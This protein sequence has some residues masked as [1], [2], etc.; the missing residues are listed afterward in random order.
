M[1][2]DNTIYTTKEMA[3]ALGMNGKQLRRYLRKMEKYNDGIYT[4]YAWTKE[5]YTKII[6]AIKGTIDKANKDKEK[7]ETK[8][9]KQA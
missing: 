6:K 4:R 1:A 3:N 2:K 7:E 9:E 5:D 8:E